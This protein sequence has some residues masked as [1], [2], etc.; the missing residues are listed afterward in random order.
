VASAS[1]LMLHPSST[2]CL[3]MHCPWMKAARCPQLFRRFCRPRKTH[4]RLTRDG[5]MPGDH[6]GPGDA[7]FQHRQR[8]RNL[9]HH[10]VRR[11]V[12]CRGCE[13]V[14]G[15]PANTR[16]ARMPIKNDVV[17]LIFVPL[18]NKSEDRRDSTTRRSRVAESST[19]ETAATTWRS[20]PSMSTTTGSAFPP[21]M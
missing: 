9:Q 1:C 18:G 12:L 14:Q 4:H 3:R 17:A 7:F 16:A 2:P 19:A 5:L 8:R 15:L 11:T 10:R 13:H 6:P 21:N 20:P